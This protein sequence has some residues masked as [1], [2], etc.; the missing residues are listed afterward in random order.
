MSDRAGVLVVG[1]GL[2]GGEWARAALRGRRAGL[3]LAG[4]VDPAAAAAERAEARGVRLWPDLGAALA[5]ARP[6]AA[7]VASPA[8]L[9]ADHALACLEAG[10]AVLVE[11]PLAASLA[12]ATRIAEAARR[13]GLPAL[14]A[15][16][17]R[18]R[19]VELTLRRA[20]AS[21]AIGSTR[22]ACIVSAR[23]PSAPPAGARRDWPLWEF[24]VHHVDLWRSRLGLDP[25]RV[26][27][28][29]GGDGGYL[30]R[31]RFPGPVDVLYRHRE[32]APCFH[33]YEWVEGETGALAVELERVR[34]HSSRHRPR[35]LRRRRA[36]APELALLD[37]LAA[38][39]AGEGHDGPAGDLAAEAN[40]G[41]IA[42]LQAAAD[43]LHSGRPEPVGA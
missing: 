33:W 35:R 9:H 41:T 7:I 38:A 5:E 2:R 1:F 18:F 28:E 22:A 34:L 13:A 15:Q 11:K 21:G 30:L 25:E 36:P 6:E 32:Q 29:A 12:D 19:R 8:P 40:L 24:C 39:L 20:L 26:E 43:S 17:F 14:V 27:A 4:V 23:A 31:L 37:T 42:T 3:E 10:C 16:N